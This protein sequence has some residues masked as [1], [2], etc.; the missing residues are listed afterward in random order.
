MSQMIILVLVK[1]LPA[2]PDDR[3]NRNLKSIRSLTK[4]YTDVAPISLS[5][6][7]IPT[8]ADQQLHA[9]PAEKIDDQ[10]HK[11]R[12]EYARAELAKE[13]TEDQVVIT[14]H[15]LPSL[16]HYSYLCLNHVHLFPYYSLF[17]I[18]LIHLQWSIMKCISSERSHIMSIQDRLPLINHHYAIAKE[19]NGNGLMSMGSDSML[20]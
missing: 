14:Y 5:K 15:D 10:R 7:G 9:L 8:I 3:T 17:G 11:L 2:I 19:F 20:Y 4:L 1:V 12:L 18:L 16:L 13:Q 6:D